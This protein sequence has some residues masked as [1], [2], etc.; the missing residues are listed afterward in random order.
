M[1]HKIRFGQCRARLR[2]ALSASSARLQHVFGSPQARRA[3]TAPSAFGA[4]RPE[5]GA[6]RHRR[7]ALRNSSNHVA[8]TDNGMST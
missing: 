7:F 3:F 1:F 2:R 5:T 4:S 8:Q 6:A